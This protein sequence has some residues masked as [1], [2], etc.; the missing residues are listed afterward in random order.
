MPIAY[1]FLFTLVSTAIL[2]IK[3]LNRALQHFDSTQVIP[4]QFVLFTLSVIIGSAILYRDFEKID[5]QRL[6]RFVVG[7]A[8]TFAGVYVL[9]AGRQKNDSPLAEDE[10]E[11]STV[12]DNVDQR[13]GEAH[14][15]ANGYPPFLDD[16][17]DEMN[18]LLQGGERDVQRAIQAVVAPLVTSSRQRG[19]SHSIQRSADT[20][21]ASSLQRN[22]LTLIPP[23]V[24]GV[25]LHA[26][27]GDVVTREGSRRP[28]LRRQHSGGGLASAAEPS[29]ASEGQERNHDDGESDSKWED[30]V[31]RLFGKKDR[32]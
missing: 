8:L 29:A 10:N 15:S 7:C 20:S 25:Q 32:S 17:L 26:V 27:A 3:Y 19:R 11:S 16:E 21:L 28:S 4:T 14:P 2:Q 24:A 9:S 23:I 6:F 22:S 31:M 30:R 5:N 18:P 1:P 13:N 12:D